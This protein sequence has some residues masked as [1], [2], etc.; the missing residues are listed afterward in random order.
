MKRRILTDEQRALQMKNIRTTA[1]IKKI[2]KDNMLYRKFHNMNKGF[3]E[4]I[5]LSFVKRNDANF[6]D[7]VQ[8]GQI[9]LI[10]A[11][12]KYNQN[13]STSLS[14]F[15]YRVISNDILQAIKK[16]N[17]KN[18][19]E[20]SLERFLRITES[21]EA[22]EYTEMYFTHDNAYN[23]FDSKILDGIVREDMFNQFS[24]LEKNI[25]RL[26][27]DGIKL[28]DIPN[29]LNISYGLMK[30]LLYQKIMPKLNGMNI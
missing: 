18:Y 20:T 4:N 16:Q 13:S 29:H 26:R 28:K 22:G 19:H 8:E 25:L 7:L 9:S 3:I 23:N 10:K 15:A 1:V 11:M 21:G 6:D 24:D 27:E 30:E 12:R 5:V 14:T 2:L 17:K